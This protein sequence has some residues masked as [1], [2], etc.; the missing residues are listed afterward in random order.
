MLQQGQV[1]ELTTRGGDGERLWAYRFRV[2]GR[3]SKRI[4]RGGFVS[5]RDAREALERELERIRRERR[6]PRSLTLAELVESYL[7]QHDV[8][9][10]TIEK[11]RWLLAKA[12]AVSASAGSTS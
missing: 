4:Q 6:I 10:V 2:G 1:F 12:T 9:P 3:G 7:A 8:Q 5:E 11:L